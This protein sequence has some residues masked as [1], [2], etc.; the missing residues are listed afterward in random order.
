MELLD[1]IKSELGMRRLMPTGARV[2]V[3]VSGGLDSMTLLH[4]LSQLGPKFGW[5]LFG[6]HFNHQLRGRSSD[7][8]ECLVTNVC[9]KLR[10]PCCVGRGDVKRLAQSS[11]ESLEMAARTLRHEFFALTAKR[12]KCPI[13][14]LAHHADDQV[15]LFFLRLLRGSSGDGL[16]GMKW[17]TPSPIHPAV[18]LVRPFLGVTRAEIRSYAK[19]H[20]LNFRHDKSNDSPKHLRNRVRLE[21]LPLLRKQYQPRLNDVV[22]RL[23]EL[24]GAEADYVGEVAEQWLQRKRSPTP[25]RSLPAALQRRVIEL[26]LRELKLRA[27]F[28]LVEALRTRPNIPMSYNRAKEVLCDEAGKVFVPL[29]KSLVFDCHQR[30]LNL[31]HTGNVSFGELNLSWNVT[32][33]I[34]QG[35]PRKLK[36]T[37]RFDSNRIGRSVILRHWQPG[38]RFQPIGMKSAIKLQDWLTNLKV[39]AARRRELVLATTTK[40]EIFWVQGQRIAEGFKLTE[41]TVNVLNWRWSVG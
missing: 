3:G 34:A 26:Q 11:G 4:V 12:L 10:I 14:A 33:G 41:K 28:D 16:A 18:E 36:N 13:V 24:V 23:M 27:D 29:R 15:E 6:A 38:D 30:R 40:G 37:E 8:D 25:W 31:G 9:K 17:S 32:P 35:S 21:L 20:Q 19:S 39:P 7:A 1:Q 22:S 5:R 2:L